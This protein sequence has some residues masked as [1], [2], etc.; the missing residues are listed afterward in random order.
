MDI[1]RTCHCGRSAAFARGLPKTRTNPTGQAPIEIG[2]LQIPVKPRPR[3]RAGSI[4]DPPCHHGGSHT[5]RYRFRMRGLPPDGGGYQMPERQPPMEIGGTCIYGALVSFPQGAP[6]IQLKAGLG[7]LGSSLGRSI[8]A[9]AAPIT[10]CISVTAV[11]KS[12]PKPAVRPSMGRR[13]RGGRAMFPKPAGKQDQ[14]EANAEGQEHDKLK[15][16]G[17]IRSAGEPG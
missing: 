5:G 1:V 15:A 14:S 13:T 12:T 11:A 17:G 9:V 3:G 8:A 10:A 4:H 7:G 2:G 16:H 6:N